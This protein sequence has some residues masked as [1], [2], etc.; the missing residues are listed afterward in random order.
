MNTPIY[1]F[2]NKYI[3]MDPVRLHMPGHKGRK[4]YG[5]DI[6]EIDGADFLSAPLG[7]IAESEKNASELFGCDTFYSVE[8]SSLCIRAM[9]FMIKKKAEQEGRKPAILA[10]RNVHVSF[11]NACALLDIKVDFIMPL[12]TESYESCTVTGKD[13]D[14][15]SVDGVD[16]VFV[17]SPD[18]LGNML[19]I[20]ELA[21]ACH[22]HGIYLMVDNAHGAYLKF[23]DHSLF[24]TDMGADICCSSAHKTLSVLTG[25]AYLHINKNTDRF[26]KE[27]ARQALAAFA[28]TSPSYLIL[29]SLDL[30]NSYISEEA[31]KNE[32]YIIT[33]RKVGLLK[34]NLRK[35]GFFVLK[36]EP[37]KVTVMSVRPKDPDCTH[38]AGMLMNE[39]IY[40]EFY[41]R[42][43]LVL[44][45]SPENSEED[46]TRLKNAL[47][48]IRDTYKNSLAE[49]DM[50]A[51]GEGLIK[52]ENFS[53]RGDRIPAPERRMSFS[54]AMMS[55]SEYVDVKDSVGRIMASPVLSC[56]PCVPVY[57]YGEVIRSDIMEYYSG[58][59]SVVK[60]DKN[61]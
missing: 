44:M 7:I 61:Q 60:T 48:K 35:Q 6:T 52:T 33:A 25:G 15:Y 9:L 47:K 46:Y 2:V 26:F 18:Y 43:Y 22:R 37:L 53:S 28:S 5:K 45:F 58:K 41:D 13:I 40:P 29:Q 36:N 34:E 8:G 3:N 30:C 39:R 19:D 24:P 11:I 10:G 12:K 31:I 14:E 51:D 55:A 4:G 27:N 17:T 16:A 59:I 38:I 20:S 49:G 42:N 54:E 57:M 50:H 32:V 21:E 1:D 56:P 23:L